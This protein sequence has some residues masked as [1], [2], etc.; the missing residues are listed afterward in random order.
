MVRG[1]GRKSNKAAVPL[2]LHREMCK[3]RQARFQKK[4]KK[5]KTKKSSEEE[6]RGEQRR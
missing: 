5:K 4:K 3:V 2:G 1:Q 6:S